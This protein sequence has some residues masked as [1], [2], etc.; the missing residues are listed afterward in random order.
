MRLGELPNCLLNCASAAR[1]KR[2]PVPGSTLGLE[3][4]AVA[5]W[6]V[7]CGYLEVRRARKRPSGVSPAA[8]GWMTMPDF[9]LHI[10]P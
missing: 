2:Q 4:D 3:Y 6:R 9:A 10:A 5:L 7:L 8:G 1:R